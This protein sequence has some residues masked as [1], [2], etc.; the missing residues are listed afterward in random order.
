MRA[1]ASPSSAALL[2]QS[3]STVHSGFKVP[4]QVMPDSS[5]SVSGRSNQGK[6]IAQADAILWDEAPMSGKDV[7]NCVDRLLRGLTGNWHVPFGGKVVVFGIFDRHY[8]LLV[9]RDR[10]KLFL[11]HCKNVAFGL[12]SR[13]SV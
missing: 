7:V 3:A 6:L 8:L 1:V 5:C 12:M 9:V 4:L 10:L 2:L 13:C 11:R